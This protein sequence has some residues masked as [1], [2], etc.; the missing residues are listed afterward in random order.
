MR[1]S[2]RRQPNRR[3][4]LTCRDQLIAHADGCG[5]GWSFLEAVD[6][7]GDRWV[8]GEQGG[9]PRARPERIGDHAVFTPLTYF[10]MTH[11]SSTI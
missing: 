7:L 6:A 1:R 8:G 4:D 3:A 5:G 9:Q 11:T 10:R 2:A